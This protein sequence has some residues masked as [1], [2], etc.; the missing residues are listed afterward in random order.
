MRTKETGGQLRYI[1]DESKRGEEK[2]RAMVDPFRLFV[3]SVG[4]KVCGQRDGVPGW[5]AAFEVS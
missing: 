1:G 5:P 3:D 4:A 2:K